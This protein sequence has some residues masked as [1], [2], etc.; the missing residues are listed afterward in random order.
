MVD[1]Y[2]FLH[3]PSLFNINIQDVDSENSGWCYILTCSDGVGRSGTFCA[4][5]SI[6]ERVKLEQVVD[7]FQA[8]KALRV[9][10]PG[11][12]KTS[13]SFY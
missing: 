11:A 5:Y 4:I 3:P 13:V 7:V 9:R 2:I 8:V 12:L 6:L 10:R 1:L